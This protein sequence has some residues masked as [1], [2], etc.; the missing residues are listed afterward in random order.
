MFKI[1]RKIK[2]R[3]ST[4]VIFVILINLLSPQVS[5]AVKSDEYLLIQSIFNPLQSVYE[6]ITQNVDEK[7]EENE[8]EP[9][10]SSSYNVQGGLNK[11]ETPG[12][13]VVFTTENASLAAG[14]KVTATAIPSFFKKS[15]EELNYVWYLKRSGCHLSDGSEKDKNGDKLY[16]DKIDESKCDEDRDGEI[17]END[18]KISATKIMMAGS[19]NENELTAKGESVLKDLYPTVLDSKTEKAAGYMADELER[20]Y[21]REPESGF[22]YELQRVEAKFNPCPEG[23]KLACAKSDQSATC[24]VLNPAY[25][26]DVATQNLADIEA[27]KAWNADPANQSDPAYPMAVPEPYGLYKWDGSLKDPVPAEYPKSV[28]SQTADFCSVTNADYFC[29]ITDETDLLKYKASVDCYDGEIPMC[30]NASGNTVFPEDVDGT[31][32]PYTSV[33]FGEDN[34]C[35][36]LSSNDNVPSITNLYYPL[37]E[38]PVYLP[39]FDVPGINGTGSGVPNPLFEDLVGQD[40]SASLEITGADGDCEFV[41]SDEPLC[42]HIFAK[43]SSGETGDGSFTLAEMQF[44]GADPTKTS[45]KEKGTYEEIVAGLGAEEFTWMYSDG[46]QIGV[47]IEGE[48][49]Y[50]TAHSDSTYKKT[51]AFSKGECEALTNLTDKLELI[52]SD[53]S[54]KNRRGLY[55]EGPGGQECNPNDR[56]KCVAFL[57]AEMDPNDCL[58]D[59]LLDPVVDSP[60]KLGIE[61]AATPA[62][63]VNDSSGNGDTLIV[64]ASPTNTDNSNTLQY[65]WSIQKS[66]DGAYSPIDTTQWLDITS[67]MQSNGAFS[68]SEVKGLNKKEFSIDLNMAEELIQ[69]GWSDYDIESFNAE[70]VFYLKVKL[71]IKAGAADGSQDAEGSIIIRITQQQN[72]MN[73]YMAKEDE[74]EDNFGKVLLN[75]ENEADSF[76]DQD[77]CYVAKDNIVGVEIPFTDKSNKD[78][79]FLWAINDE[80]FTCPEQL[81]TE[82]VDN[83]DANV[84]FFPVMGNIGEIISVTAKGIDMK[85]EAIELS[86]QFMIG[87]NILK[88]TPK[89]VGSCSS[90]CTESNNICPKF[91]GQYYDLANTPY[92]DCSETV[93][94]AKSGSSI[95]LSANSGSGFIW[96]IDGMEEFAGEQNIQL[97]MEKNPGE[98]YNISLYSEGASPERGI[99]LALFNNWGISQE[100]TVT[101]S[102][103][104]T[105]QINV[106]A[107]TE[108]VAV[109]KKT[110]FGASLITYL[111]EQLMF[112]LKISLTS[113][114]LFFLT[115][116]LFSF[117]PERI[118]EKR[119]E[120]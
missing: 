5:L 111:P 31:T 52:R 84:L 76:C 19:T 4:S 9:S 70:G 49:N 106:V 42:E 27:A 64:K 53:E 8:K 61:L 57:T 45:I 89:D 12:V 18:W 21:V 40:C 115:G 7:V 46:D 73:A 94:E 112:L 80:V 83:P 13:K 43:P 38:Y 72:K 32:E 51:W 63:P 90:T 108:E 98:S 116:V 104:A 10:N 35:S 30:V 54:N 11:S 28:E 44:W 100:E 58:K 95:D 86:K 119:E 39:W 15:N 50:P 97:A 87:S 118:F 17:T 26:F 56:S 93:F 96:T 48:S 33:V 1:K 3:I 67:D 22:D 23:K 117:M 41:Q 75:K 82:C 16:D 25:D 74:N 68:S 24:N 81:S 120:D 92:P 14:A 47:V 105:M 99:R 69:N 34:L 55:F 62:N 6:K 59:N 113:L 109:S 36:S 107:S 71:S 29:K 91:L 65:E 110:F 37:G 88:I 78:V 85:G 66:L 79:P 103:T 77:Y 101:E 114:A 60:S 102:Q 20:C 2:A